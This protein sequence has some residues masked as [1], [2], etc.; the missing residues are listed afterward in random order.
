EKQPT[1]FARL[2]WT[3]L[4]ERGSVWMSFA[5]GLS[6]STPP[7][8]FWGAVMAIAA[9]GAAVGTQVTAAVVFVLVAFGIAEIPLVGYLAFPTK[10][11]AVVMQVHGWMAA[12]RRQIMIYM[13][14]LFGIFMLATGVGNF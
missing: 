2:S 7:L 1:G 12:H 10:T 14:G 9:S 6:T 11:Q 5:A 3:K 8:E 4:V 13:F